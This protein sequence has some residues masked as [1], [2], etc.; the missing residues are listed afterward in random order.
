MCHLPNSTAILAAFLMTIVV[1]PSGAE[2]PNA[3]A[4]DVKLVAAR[5]DGSELTVLHPRVVTLEGQEACIEIGPT[6]SPPAGIAVHEPF[7][8]GTHL[9][10]KVYRNDGKLILD[11]AVSKS[12]GGADSEGVAITSTTVRVLKAITLEKMV[13]IPVE[14]TKLRWELLVCDPKS[15]RLGRID[16][17]GPVATPCTSAASPIATPT[18]AASR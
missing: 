7:H 14:N 6:M 16:G 15:E 12:S 5:A 10:A 18:A 11:A 9:L 4:V 1:A 3:Y 8:A 17:D 2:T 13:V